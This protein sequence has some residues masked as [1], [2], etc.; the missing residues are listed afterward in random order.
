M[1]QCLRLFPPY[2]KDKY[3]AELHASPAYR[4]VPVE[5]EPLALDISRAVNQV[6]TPTRVH[7]ILEA[8]RP[9]MPV[10]Q[11]T[12]QEPKNTGIRSHSQFTSH[13]HSHRYSLSTLPGSVPASWAASV[14]RGVFQSSLACSRFSSL[15]ARSAARR[16]S[17][18][19]RRA[20][21]RSGRYRSRSC[22]R[23][24]RR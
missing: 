7:Y 3:L 14:F 20:A 21:Q 15:L 6:K 5:G 19:C 24:Q 12:C 22:Q 8:G 23:R 1:R 9:Q 13:F 18:R 16:R 17:R 10:S 2:V 4:C 11:V